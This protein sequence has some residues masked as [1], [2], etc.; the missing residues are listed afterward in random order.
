VAD[1]LFEAFDLHADRGLR[2]CD[3]LRRSGET[4]GIGDRGEAAQQ[5]DVEVG[6]AHDFYVLDIRMYAI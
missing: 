3:K 1:D 6:G 4:A 5:V 2:A